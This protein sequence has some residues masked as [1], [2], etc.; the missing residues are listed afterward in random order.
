MIDISF[1]IKSPGVPVSF[2]IESIVAFIGAI[3]S[4][5]IFRSAPA[6]VPMTSDK[7]PAEIC[8]FVTSMPVTLSFVYRV[9]EKSIFARSP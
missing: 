3:R 1:V 7:D 6:S 2:T 4:N 8:P 9:V 5:A